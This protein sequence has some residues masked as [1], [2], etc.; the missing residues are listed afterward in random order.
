MFENKIIRGI[1]ISRYIASWTKS[2]GTLKR[3]L[4]RGFPAFRA[5]LRTL[6]IDGDHLTKDEIRQICDY[7]CNGKLE[8]ETSAKMFLEKCLM[9]PPKD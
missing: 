1:H 4:L 3:N 7:A 5:W 8:L 9:R 6:E 2:G